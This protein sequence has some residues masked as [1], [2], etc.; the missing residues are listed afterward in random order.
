MASSVG[1]SYAILKGHLSGDPEKAKRFL[2]SLSEGERTMRNRSESRAKKRVKKR[3]YRW[4]DTKR[5]Y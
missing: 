5:G 3:G 4:G 2:D 1:E